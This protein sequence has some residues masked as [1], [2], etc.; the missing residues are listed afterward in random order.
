M[1]HR[2]R[3]GCLVIDCQTDDLGP[4]TR[5]WAAALGVTG[6]VD[7]DGKYAVLADRKGYP[8]L[9]VQAVD[10]ASR[11]HLDIE[12]DDREAE[13]VRLEGLGAK[14]IDRVRGWIVMEAPTGHRFCIVKPQGDD[15]PGNAREWDE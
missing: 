15:F 8:K 1:A 10:H 12:T 11:V 13:A 4:A 14:V 7:E 6:K 3:L 5:F 9:L 2:S